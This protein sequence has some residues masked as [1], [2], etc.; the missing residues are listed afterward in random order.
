MSYL[1]TGA[2]GQLGSTFARRLAAGARQHDDANLGIGLEAL[3][4]LAHAAPH[5]E[6]DRVELVGVVEDDVRDAALAS[7]Q[8]LV[9]HVVFT[10]L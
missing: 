5:L 7:G 4:G 8:D 2:A 9:G 1:I 10:F 3:H 6:R